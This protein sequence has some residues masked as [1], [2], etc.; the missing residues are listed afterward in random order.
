MF[1]LCE[2]EISRLDPLRCNVKSRKDGILRIA[3]SSIR[4]L[5][6]S[7]NGR[8]FSNGAFTRLCF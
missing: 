4:A 1:V 6:Y 7:V 5:K 2:V 3:F 8:F